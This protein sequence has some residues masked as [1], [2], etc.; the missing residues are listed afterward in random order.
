MAYQSLEDII[1]LC[2]EK[3]IPFWEAILQ[4]DINERTIPVEESYDKMREMWHAMLRASEGYQKELMSRS[5]L[6]GG[7]GGKMEAYRQS[8]QTLC[9]DFMSRV[10][11]QA[12]EMGE[13]NACMKRIVAAPTA[14]ACG[15]LPAVLVPLYQ[16]GKA[17]EDRMIEALYVAAGIGQVIAAR[18]FIAGA[19]GGCQAEIGSASAMAAG[20]L[21]Y[22]K[23]GS[24]GQIVHGAAMALKNLLGLVCDPVAGLVEVPCV[25]RNVIGAVNGLSCADMALAG[26]ESRIPPDQ[27][28]DAMREVGEK[29]DESLKETGKGGIANTPAGREVW[30]KVL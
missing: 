12:L 10:I 3:D 6:V 14:G 19:S 20:A 24:N 23:G 4:D 21:V 30:E 11:V 27:V 5:G 2:E 7:M 17:P 25:K 8:G 16:E 29:M 1:K 15:V 22:L 26:I 9:G 13:S 28:I 18:A